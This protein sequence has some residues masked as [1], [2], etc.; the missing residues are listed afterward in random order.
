MPQK[1][2][3]AK[4]QVDDG[5]LLPG[6]DPTAG[7]PD[8]ALHWAQVYRELVEFKNGAIDRLVI[9]AVG[10][11]DAARQEIESTD[12]VVLRA[13]RDRFRRRAETWRDRYRKLTGE[14]KS[15]PP[16]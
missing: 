2:Q 5:R 13:E 9:A 15:P 4:D 8:D 7:H 6:E 11:G 1:E 10:L 14:A 12:L 3:A 16:E